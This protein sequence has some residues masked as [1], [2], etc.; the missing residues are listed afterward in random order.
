MRT[1]FFIKEGEIFCPDTKGNRRGFNEK[2]IKKYRDQTDIKIYCIEDEIKKYNLDK[3]NSNP[4]GLSKEENSFKIWYEAYLNRNINVSFFSVPQKIKTDD[5]YRNALEKIFEKYKKE[6]KRP[7]FVY[8]EGFLECVEGICDSII[9]AVDC[10]IDGNKMEAEE[11]LIRKLSLFLEEP[12]LVSDL[13]GSYAFRMNAPFEILRDRNLDYEPM[14]KTPLTFYRCRCKEKSDSDEINQID[15]MYHVPYKLRDKT[16]NMRF[17]EQGCPGL[18]LS[19]ATYTCSQECSWKEDAQDLYASAFVPND[20]G[21][22]Y[23]ILNL[24]VSAPLIDGVYNPNI[25][26]GEERTNLEKLQI[27]MLKV[28]PFVIATSF[29]VTNGGACN[30]VYLLSQALMKAVG[31]CGIDGIAYL[32]ARGENA[33]EFPQMVNLAIP[34]TDISEDKQYSDKC[35]GF[36]VSKPVKFRCQKGETDKSY[37]N[38]IL[39]PK[40]KYGFDNFTAKLKVDG[41]NQFYGDTAYGQFDNYL[42]SL[43]KQENVDKL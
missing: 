7:A 6:L 40:D 38:T 4:F 20:K 23:K 30:K 8:K 42:V 12:F 25:D 32:S 29:S 17:S 31:K 39:P 14:M 36:Y 1:Y 28:F 2:E 41:K 9:K 15:K 43:L 27:S 13:D 22:K 24:T 10:L 34:A 19:V 33:F 18:Y 3:N 16:S 5:E 35:F 26:I 11:I 37:I 21:K